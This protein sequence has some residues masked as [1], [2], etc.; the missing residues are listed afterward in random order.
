MHKTGAPVRSSRDDGVSG[1]AAGVTSVFSDSW[2][3][4]VI[5]AEMQA[6]YVPVPV[7]GERK[8]EWRK[9]KSLTDSVHPHIIRVQAVN[10][11]NMQ[12]C[13]IGMFAI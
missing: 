5:F 4:W 6:I 3:Q 7:L 1:L 10:F 8:N 12:K 11:W 2:K 13:R 9:K